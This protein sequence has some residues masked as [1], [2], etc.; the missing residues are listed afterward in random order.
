MI[1]RPPGSTRTDTLVPYTT[2][3]RSEGFSKIN[4]KTFPAG[5][6]QVEALVAGAVDIV[7]PAQGP[8]L[9]LSSKGFPIVVLSS[10]ATYNDAFECA[11]RKSLHI[12]KPKHIE[13]LKRWEEHTSELQSLMHIS[14]AVR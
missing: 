2:L 10:L 3:F 11:I 13:V 14:D 6:L 7:N 4:L 5:Q 1:R 9:T 12:T 8:V